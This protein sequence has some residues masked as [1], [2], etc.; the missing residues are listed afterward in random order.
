MPAS[1]ATMVMVAPP[2]TVAA[3]A[4]QVTLAQPPTGTGPLDCVWQIGV[5]VVSPT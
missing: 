2:L 3:G 5:V 4:S 1:L